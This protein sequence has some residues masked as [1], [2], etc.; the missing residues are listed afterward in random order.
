MSE[1]QTK[2]NP[3]G[4]GGGSLYAEALARV[5]QFI[6]EGNVMP[7]ERIVER[8]LCATLAVSRT[9]LREALKVLAAEGL[10][11]LLPN[12]GAIVRRMSVGEVRDLF[13]AFA[14]LEFATG[15]LACERINDAAIS[16][17]TQLHYAMYDRYMRKDIVEYFRLN[18]AIHAAFLSATESPTLQAMSRNLSA[19]LQQLRF[20]AN[21]L[22]RDRWGEAMREHEAMLDALQRRD[23]NALG[24]AL[25]EHMRRKC[26]AACEGIAK[27]SAREDA[28]AA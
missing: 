15:M 20:T 8:H 26:E 22:E 2:E 9:P 24:R 10:I 28:N 1:E 7:G 27:Q 6:V 4:S 14:G 21:Q 3:P 25:F 19:R 16:E 11:A 13:E 5:R 23:G 17:I 12:R 18:Q